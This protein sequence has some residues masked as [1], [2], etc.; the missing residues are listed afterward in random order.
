M[1]AFD[2]ML[3]VALD[4]DAGGKG[5]EDLREGWKG[6]GKEEQG[7]GGGG[8]WGGGEEGRISQPKATK[9]LS[10]KRPSRDAR[11]LKSITGVTLESSPPMHNSGRYMFL[12]KVTP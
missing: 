10:E 2:A 1:Q 12:E 8:G 6:R 11:D 3:P 5:E 4:N 7:S 9:G